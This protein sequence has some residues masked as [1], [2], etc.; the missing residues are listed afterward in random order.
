MSQFDE[1]PLIARSGSSYIYRA[2]PNSRNANEITMWKCLVR[3][4]VIGLLQLFTSNLNY[5]SLWQYNSVQFSD[6][7]FCKF[8][9]EEEIVTRAAK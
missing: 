9:E 4:L 2:F 1:G 3:L 6:P 5:G 7:S 8:I